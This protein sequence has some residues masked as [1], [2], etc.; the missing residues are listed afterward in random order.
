M[1]KSCVRRGFTLVEML[2]VI[3]IIGILMALLLPAVQSA[4]ESARMAQCMNNVKQ[5]CLAM[6]TFHTANRSFPPGLPTCMTWSATNPSPNYQYVNGSTASTGAC[7]CCGPNWELAILPQMDN[8]PMYNSMLFC[9]DSSTTKNVC[10]ECAVSGTNASNSV[11][12]LGYNVTATGSVG[13]IPPGYTCP[14]AE[15]T[16]LRSTPRAASAV[17][18]R[19]FQKAT[20]P[21]AGAR[22]PGCHSS[23]VTFRRSIQPTQVF[24]ALRPIQASHCFSTSACSISPSSIS[25]PQRRFRRVALGWGRVR[26]CGSRI[27]STEPRTPPWF[28]S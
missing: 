15:I 24:R 17:C 16:S 3:T 6:Q 22:T 14:S 27:A 7:T 11:T 2:V 19:I 12:W 10:S 4:R 13:I 25:A 18:R 21:A 1:C 28:Q 20:T 5:L 26:A 9:M 8:Q 23:R